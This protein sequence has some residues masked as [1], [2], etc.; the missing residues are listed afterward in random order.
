LTRERRK[1]K[2]DENND[3][4]P[5]EVR[6][7]SSVHEVR[8][9]QNFSILR[10]MIK[11]LGDREMLISA[12]S[13]DPVLPEKTRDEAVSLLKKEQ[14]ENLSAFHDFLV[15]FVTMSMQG[16]HR[17]EITLE[18]TFQDDG[19]YWVHGA[20]LHVDGKPLL[21]P[22]GEGPRLMASISPVLVAGDPSQSLLSF[23]RSCEE[24]HDREAGS[25]LESC[26]LELTHEIFP[27]TSY[28][29]RLRLPAYRYC[30]GEAAGE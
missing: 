19:T 15:N 10:T 16:L 13:R 7:H 8:F 6:I 9:W 28:R 3:A 23:Y 5:S 12:L 4:P 29:A 20:T 27:G 11:H 17:T 21:L 30:N 2:M 25:G 1:G 14:T 26:R 24:L 22:E 18:F